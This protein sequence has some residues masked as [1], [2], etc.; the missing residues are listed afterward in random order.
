MKTIKEINPAKYSHVYFVD[1]QKL[2]T[3]C[4]YKFIG[5]FNNVGELVLIDVKSWKEVNID[6]GNNSLRKAYIGV[7]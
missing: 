1:E 3:V 6:F 2:Y 7:R 5:D 4:P